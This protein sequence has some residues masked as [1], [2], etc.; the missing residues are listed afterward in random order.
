[1]KSKHETASGETRSGSM[2]G[3]CFSSRAREGRKAPNHSEHSDLAFWRGVQKSLKVL[4]LIWA[5]QQTFLVS[6][7]KA[8]VHQHHILFQPF[9]KAPLNRWPGKEDSKKSAIEVVAVLS[10]GF[11]P[12]AIVPSLVALCLGLLSLSTGLTACCFLFGD[13][14]TPRSVSE[15]GSECFCGPLHTASHT[16]PLLQ[17]LLRTHDAEPVAWCLSFCRSSAQFPW[18][19]ASSAEEMTNAL[20]GDQVEL[21]IEDEFCFEV[22]PSKAA[23]REL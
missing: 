8:S 6:S 17:R 20:N 7:A 5:L 4:D 10:I 19:V 2:C 16:L 13:S 1:M 3:P 9:P 21:L 15:L 18:L 23:N 14:E 12:S 22:A 11:P